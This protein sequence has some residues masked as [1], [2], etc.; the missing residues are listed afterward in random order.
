MKSD[1]SLQSSHIFL[2]NHLANKVFG[3]VHYAYASYREQ[4]LLITPVSSQWFAK[5]YEASQFL[6]KTK[7]GNGDRAIAIHEI[8]IENDIDVSDRDLNYEIISK[9]NLIKINL[10]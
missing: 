4:Q 3:Q 8:L 2:E 1:I 5:M 9:T 7:N 6:L 10:S